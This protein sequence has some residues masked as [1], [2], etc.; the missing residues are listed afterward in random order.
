MKKV[1]FLLIVIALISTILQSC[2]D[3]PSCTLLATSQNVAGG[4]ENCIGDK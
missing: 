2:K 4:H 1:K 3:L